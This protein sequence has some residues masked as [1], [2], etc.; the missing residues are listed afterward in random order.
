M[1]STV[2]TQPVPHGENGIQPPVSDG[3]EPLNYHS[4]LGG[5]GN[6]QFQPVPTNTA[7]GGLGQASDPAQAD[8]PGQANGP[9]QASGPTQATTLSSP[10]DSKTSENNTLQEDKERGGQHANHS[11]GEKQG[12]P[13]MRPFEHNFWDPS[14]KQLRAIYFKPVVM[15]TLLM[16]IVIWAFL[17]MYWGS[18]WKELELSPNLHVMVV[19]YDSGEIGQSMV[20]ALNQSNYGSTPHPTYDFVDPK[21]FPDDTAVMNAIEPDELYW[22][23]VQI[24]QDA[25]SR[26]TTARAN[27]DAS[28][29]PSAVVT[30]TTATARNYAVVPS[31]V[32]SP[33]QTTLLKAIASLNARLTGNFVS[34]S[35]SNQGALTAAARAPQTLGNPV[36]LTVREIRPWDVPVAIAPT[37]VGLIYLVILTFQ[38]TMASFGARQP[39]QKFLRLRSIIAMRIFTPAL[40][41][42]PISL[43]YTLLNI[44]FKLPYDATFPYGGGVMVWWCVSY[45]G[46]LVLGLAMESMVT[47]V[48]VKFIG[49]FLIFFIVTNVSVANFPPELSPSFYKYGYAMPF[50]NLRQI[51]LTILFNVGK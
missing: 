2:T 40:A 35:V 13:N 28:W 50:Y 44:P 41:Y 46:M 15:T 24:M 43:M 51:Y 42:I 16:M 17:S 4:S 8:G 30:I 10:L 20:Q 3:R 33:T 29:N 12:K 11:A 32:L 36:G 1:S 22:G 14:L 23:A 26:L 6:N 47:I 34:A 19:N 5:W 25:T 45:T 48:G 27:G 7:G 18:L 21:D 39:I 31:I 37:F 49:I 38:I 9:G